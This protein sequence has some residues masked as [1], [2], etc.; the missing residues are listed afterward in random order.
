MTG[1]PTTRRV[2]LSYDEQVASQN[3]FDARMEG[4]RQEGVA[5][6]SCGASKESC[7]YQGGSQERTAW[8]GGYAEASLGILLQLNSDSGHE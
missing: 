8:V 5:A 7:P 1:N 6:F 2:P 3:A 4:I